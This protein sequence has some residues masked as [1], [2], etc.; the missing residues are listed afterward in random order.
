MGWI[1]SESTLLVPLYPLLCD[2][3]P[4]PISWFHWPIPPSPTRH[5]TEFLIHQ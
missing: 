1:A 3:P 4:S 2:P 5:L